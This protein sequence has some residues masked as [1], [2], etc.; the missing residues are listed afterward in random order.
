M[1]IVMLNLLIS[2]ISD[3]FQRVQSQAK[4]RMYS[5]FA[6]LIIENYHLLSDSTITELDSRGKYLYLAWLEES[7]ETDEAQ[8]FKDS[9][10][11][12]LDLNKCAIITTLKEK[13][14]AQ[15]RENQKHYETEFRALASRVEELQA[16]VRAV[17][18]KP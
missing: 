1:I 11:Q 7:V 13:L 15:D 8:E 18:A 9:I 14:D 16:Q 12:Q 10:I 2:I 6:Q 3:T 4:Q 5:E 17:A